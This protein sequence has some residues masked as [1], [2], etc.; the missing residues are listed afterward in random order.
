M[1][2]VKLGTKAMNVEVSEVFPGIVEVFDNVL[3]PRFE[4]VFEL[5]DPGNFFF[6][7]GYGG[8]REFVY[9]VIRW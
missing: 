4:W 6:Q 8:I 9:P 3:F 7:F 2:D 5:W 1:I